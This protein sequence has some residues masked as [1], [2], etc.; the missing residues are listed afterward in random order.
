[1]QIGEVGK[2]KY[3][4]VEGGHFIFAFASNVNI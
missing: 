2:I 3:A 4:S 1:M